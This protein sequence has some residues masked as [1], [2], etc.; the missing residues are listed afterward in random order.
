M[1]LLKAFADTH[2]DSFK[3]IRPEDFVNFE[4]AAFAAIEEWDAL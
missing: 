1:A 3:I 2:P 4:N